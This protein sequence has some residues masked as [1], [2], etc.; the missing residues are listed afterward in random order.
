[1]TWPALVKAAAAKPSRGAL[2]VKSETYWLKS[3]PYSFAGPDAT[4]SP[5]H[6]GIDP[7]GKPRP[8][9]EKRGEGQHRAVDQRAV[10]AQASRQTTHSRASVDIGGSFPAQKKQTFFPG[11]HPPWS[12]GKTQ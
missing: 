4:G 11:S 12:R 7:A 6:A 10:A 1:M 9:P 2:Y 5:V 8:L 3:E